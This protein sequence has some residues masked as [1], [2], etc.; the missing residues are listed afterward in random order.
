MDHGFVP[1]DAA[2]FAQ[3]IL[4]EAQPEVAAGAEPLLYGDE[5]CGGTGGKWAP[6][7]T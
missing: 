3:P 6:V 1:G 5:E 7:V 2:V 4:L